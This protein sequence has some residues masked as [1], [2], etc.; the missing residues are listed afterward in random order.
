MSRIIKTFE[1][2]D[3]WSNNANE[4][5]TDDGKV[6]K[7]TSN[8]AV[9]PLDACREYGI[10]VDVA[11]QKA[12]RDAELDA[13][14]AAYRKAYRGPSAEERAE[15]RATYGRGVKLVNVLTGHSWTT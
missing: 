6:W 11:A 10:P 8:N 12:A 9:C 15:A 3:R 2:H 14:A 5:Y 13:F 7:W 1:K 4:A